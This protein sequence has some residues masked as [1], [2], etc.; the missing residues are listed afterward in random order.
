MY[1]EGGFE[2]PRFG[3]NHGGKVLQKLEPTRK[4]WSM[5]ACSAKASIGKKNCCGKS[6]HAVSIR[7]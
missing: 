4:R 3:K 2:H 7:C 6:L 5:L 1:F